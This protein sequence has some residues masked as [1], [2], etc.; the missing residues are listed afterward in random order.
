MQST[1]PETHPH[2][3]PNPQSLK[4]YS[5]GWLV[6]LQAAGQVDA[7]LAAVSKVWERNAWAIQL[8]QVRWSADIAK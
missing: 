3:R 6:S 4:A 2:N 8:L 7:C 1:V 5:R